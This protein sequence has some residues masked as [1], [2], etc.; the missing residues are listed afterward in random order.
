MSS[1]ETWPVKT[2]SGTESINAVAIPVTALV[3]P[4]PLVTSATPVSPVAR[5]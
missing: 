3:A 5:A 2:T 4:G 1:V